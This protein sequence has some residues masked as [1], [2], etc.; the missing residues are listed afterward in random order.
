M[1]I[2]EA[3]ITTP[4]AKQL[5]PPW[6]ARPSRNCHLAGAL[7][8]KCLARPRKPPALS[9]LHADSYSCLQ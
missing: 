2:P 6:P 1:H 7:P 5:F 4:A 3:A 9:A 8:A